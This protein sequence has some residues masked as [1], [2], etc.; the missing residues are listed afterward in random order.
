MLADVTAISLGGEHSLVLLQDGSVWSSPISFRGSGTYVG[1]PK[2]FARVTKGAKYVA[3]GEYHSLFLKQDN[4]LWCTGR[5]SRGQL[6]DGS[7]TKKGKVISIQVFPG[8]KS[9]AG[10]GFHTLLLTKEGRVF[11]SGWNEFGQLGDALT[12]YRTRYR[13]AEIIGAH[14][15]ALGD[16][17]SVIL[18]KDG[19]VRAAG[20]NNRG[21]LGDGSQIMRKM[22]VKV[23]PSDVAYITAGAYHSMVVKK[24]GSVWATGWNEYGQLGDGSTTD[25]YGYVQVMESGTGVKSIDAGNRHS[26]LLL[27]DGSLW[28]TGSNEYGQLGNGSGASKKNFVQVIPEEVTIAAAGA[29]HCMVLKEDGSIWVT[30]SNK[31]GQF[32]DGTGKSAKAFFRL[33]SPFRNNGARYD[34]VLIHFHVSEALCSMFCA[35]YLTFPLRVCLSTFARLLTFEHHSALSGC[36]TETETETEEAFRHHYGKKCKNYFDKFSSE[37]AFARFRHCD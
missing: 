2:S 15:A 17:H 24:D 18:I 35:N 23:I 29:F 3:A 10:G 19:S 27:Q 22:F 37:Q 33:K 26:V 9:V 32:G 8:A 25:R 13:Q 11:S 31:Y 16:C 12:M 21:Q 34:N 36:E 20:Q 4:S 14:A 7:K 1:I 30:G 28:A 6:G 5:N